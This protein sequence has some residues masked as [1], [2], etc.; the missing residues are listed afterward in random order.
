MGPHLDAMMAINKVEPVLRYH[1]LH[2]DE[3]CTAL[4]QE[5]NGAHATPKEKRR[6]PDVEGIRLS[7]VGSSFSEFD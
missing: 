1:S 5:P 3:Q 4:R 6:E 2:S 7:F